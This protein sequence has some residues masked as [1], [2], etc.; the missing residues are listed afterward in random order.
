MRRLRAAIA[1]TLFLTPFF[2][3]CG[4]E[5]ATP[6]FQ[7]TLADGSRVARQRFGGDLIVFVSDGSSVC[8]RARSQ[9]FGT[10]SLGQ[11]VASHFAAV[12]VPA[13]SDAAREALT[14]YQAHDSRPRIIVV[15]D[16]LNHLTLHV[17][18]LD[19]IDEQRLLH[20]LQAIKA[21]GTIDDYRTRVPPGLRR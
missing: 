5:P 7:P 12:E 14:R 10:T 13:G 2:V 20:Q 4:R 19:R 21:A 15:S 8:Q 9:V 16:R 1:A 6:P 18:R 17:V 11:Y 3:S